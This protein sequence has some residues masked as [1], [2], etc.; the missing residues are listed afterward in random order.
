[1]SERSSDKG[2]KADKARDEF[3][4][5]AQENLEQLSKDLVLL[6]EGRASGRFDP[7]VLNSAFRAVHSLKGLSGLFG[8]APVSELSHHLEN[9]LDGL[10][11]GRARVTAETLDLLFE[12]VAVFHQ[13]VRHEADPSKPAP[14]PIEALLGRLDR[15]G[16]AEAENPRD[17]LTAYALDP[18]LLAVLTEYEEHRL[19]ENVR[20]GRALHRVRAVF[21]LDTIDRGLDEVKTALRPLGRDDRFSAVERT[22]RR[23]DE[24]EL[25]ILFASGASQSD[26]AGAL[27]GTSLHGVADRARR[28]RTGRRDAARAYQRA[29]RHHRG[30]A[31]VGGA[32][33]ARGH[34]QA[35]RAHER[36]R[37][38]RQR[39]RRA[40][41]GAG[42]ACG[43]SAA[44]CRSRA[45]CSARCARSS[46]SSTSSRAACSTSAWSRSGTLFDKLSR[47]VR[48]LSRDAGKEIRLLI[49]GGDTEL[50]KLIVEELSDP[51]MHVIRNAI[52]HGIETPAERRAAGKPD[53]GTVKISAEQRGSHVLI[54]IVDDGGGL[55]GDRLIE[56][57][58]ERGLLDAAEAEALTPREVHNLIFLPGV[59]T[60][61]VPDQISGRGVG[62][63]VV[64]TNIARLSGIID[65]GSERG[66]GTQLSIQLP[67][68]LA[69]VQALVVRSAGRTFCIPL[70]SVL[71]SLRIASEEISMLSRREVMTLRGHTLP[72]V[73]IEKF[74]ELA[75]DKPQP[76]RCFVVV[77]GL[78]Q[79]RVGLLVD[80]LI[81]QEDI[82]V[83][84]LGKA[85]DGT[86]GIAG[87][88]EL[89]GKRTVLVLDVAAL[90]EEATSLRTTEAA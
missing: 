84:S 59:S 77:V 27:S 34:P 28:D 54:E 23:A 31:A 7:E 89:G 44:R 5:E 20:E 36:R 65:V 69:I 13:L 74:F 12:A 30:L 79:H 14:P 33:R 50:D 56:R 51:L 42:D 60:K 68:T 88:T 78:A 9:L 63:D 57:A 15:A 26:I 52:D 70:N 47:V 19:R 55:Q 81:G 6:D 75:N 86:P 43:N 10:R 1:M 21:G 2:D 61:G 16:L 3:F 41:R 62:M 29:R 37:R 83:K 90:V 87:A 8:V 58:I 48:K 73:R 38:A 39:A 76:K 35:R 4:A 24:I 66:K 18:S 45:P 22:A 71:E 80:E 25:E 72:L 67:V 32:D 17:P 11:L 40:R 46:A 53:V 49:S 85:L 64:K 82:V